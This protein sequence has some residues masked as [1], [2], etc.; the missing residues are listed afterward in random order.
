MY[1]ITN[2]SGEILGIEHDYYDAPDP[3]EFYDFWD[4]EETECSHE[5]GEY[6]DLDMRDTHAECPW[7][8]DELYGPLQENGFYGYN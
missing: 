3:D 7:C 2:D 4:R 8:G 1:V 6:P 5:N